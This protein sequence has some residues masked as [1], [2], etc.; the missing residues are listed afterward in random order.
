MRCCRGKNSKIVAASVDDNRMRATTVGIA[1]EFP[2][3][4]HPHQ[5][6]EAQATSKN[7]LKMPTNDDYTTLDERLKS[8]T[9]WP[10]VSPS[11]DE[12]AHHGFYYNPSD[13]DSDR[14]ACY[15]CSVAVNKWKQ[16]D[17]PL[18]RHR[19]AYCECPL[20]TIYTM[21]SYPLRN[22]V[23]QARRATFGKWWPHGKLYT[24]TPFKLAGAGFVYA[25]TEDLIDRCE[26]LYCHVR[27]SGWL[28]GDEPLH[29]HTA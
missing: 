17:T 9:G 22:D 29:V 15:L 27:V 20:V 14:V 19:Q 13:R 8:F 18:D 2:Q 26:C 1:L 10:L 16:H 11:A 5:L 6:D 7:K 23:R 24:A 4:L 3:T 28:E 12:L 25:P 21:Q